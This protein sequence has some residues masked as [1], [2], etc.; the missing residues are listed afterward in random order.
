MAAYST[1]KLTVPGNTQS[2]PHFLWITAMSRSFCRADTLYRVVN[3]QEADKPGVVCPV[4]PVCGGFGKNPGMAD[5]PERVDLRSSYFTKEIE[6]VE[7]MG[8][9]ENRTPV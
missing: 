2:Y 1:N 6:I 4:L 9:P 7:K 8:L 3:G 5:L